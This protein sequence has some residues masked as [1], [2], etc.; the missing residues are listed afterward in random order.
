MNPF[1]NPRD[2]GPRSFGLKSFFILTFATEPLR[3]R[4]AS[5]TFAG[6]PGTAS[7]TGFESAQLSVHNLQYHILYPS[8]KHDRLTWIFHTFPPSSHY[9]YNTHTNTY[10][11]SFDYSMYFFGYHTLVHCCSTTSIRF[12][13]TGQFLSHS[14]RVDSQCPL[15]GAG[16]GLTPPHLCCVTQVNR[17]KVGHSPRILWGPKIP[18]PPTVRNTTFFV[19]LYHTELFFRS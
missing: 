16:I 17:F 4:S 14:L 10:H 13:P 19:K 6:S 12:L 8:D 9:T 15:T 11:E 3:V 18:K 5:L 2:H 7:I 1:C